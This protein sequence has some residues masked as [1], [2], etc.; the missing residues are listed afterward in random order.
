MSVSILGVH[1]PN[2]LPGCLQDPG[3]GEGLLQR[4][5]AALRGPALQTPPHVLGLHTWHVVTYSRDIRYHLVCKV[6]AVDAVE[7]ML[8]AS[9]E[10]KLLHLAVT[11]H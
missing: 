1:D 2:L 7:G 9:R 4:H 5:E 10:G 3:D 8:G 6:C 11:V